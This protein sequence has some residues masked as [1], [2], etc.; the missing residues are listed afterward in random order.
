LASTNNPAVP[1]AA[2]AALTRTGSC[3]GSL[4][5]FILTQRQPSA[6]TQRESC[7]LSRSREYDVK[8][9]LP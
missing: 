4:P 3:A 1:I 6:S 2:R 5:I 9:P 7:S 8:P